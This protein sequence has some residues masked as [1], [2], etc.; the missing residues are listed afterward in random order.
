MRSCLIVVT[1]VLAANAAGAGPDNITSYLMNKQASMMDLGMLRLQIDLGEKGSVAYDW[2]SDKIQVGKFTFYV[3]EGEADSEKHC[4][5]WFSEMRGNAGIVATSGKPFMN[6]S[7][8]ATK[9]AHSGWVDN[10]NPDNLYAEL[11]KKFSLQCIH[12]DFNAIAPLLGTTYSV[13][14]NPAP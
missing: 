2:D 12:G 3:S 5:N 9:F 6:Q 10:S 4:S 8:W 1:I 7:F 11:D 13:E 14:T